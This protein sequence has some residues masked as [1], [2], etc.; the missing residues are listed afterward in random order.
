MIEKRIDDIENLPSGDIDM[1]EKRKLE[2]E[3]DY[4]YDKIAKEA[5][6]RSKAKWI[7]E[8]ERNTKFFL[9]LEK[10]HQANNT[11]LEIKTDNKTV[12]SN[13]KIIEEMCHFYEN[14]YTSKSI[15]NDDINAY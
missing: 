13:G 6:I 2:T 15:K 1:N 7:T 5:Q 4:M 9:G 11:I 12:A 3:L 8:G 10:K 14:L